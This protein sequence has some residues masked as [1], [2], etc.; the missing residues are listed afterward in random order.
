MWKGVPVPSGIRPTLPICPH[1]FIPTYALLF[2]TPT[3]LWLCPLLEG[4]QEL[5]GTHR[6][7][8][9][10]TGVPTLHG[11]LGS[12]NSH[13][14]LG[15]IL[16]SLGFVSSSNILACWVTVNEGRWQTLTLPSMLGFICCVCT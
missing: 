2:C 13:M 4:E 7:C 6:F 11:F 5:G 14:A 16:K 15:G 3:A 9:L 10:P 8:A 12:P 1:A